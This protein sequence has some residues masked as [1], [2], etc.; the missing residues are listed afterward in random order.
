MTLLFVGVGV[1]VCGHEADF[2]AARKKKEEYARVSGADGSEDGTEGSV[3][4]PRERT[5]ETYGQRRTIGE[6][7][8]TRSARACLVQSCLCRG[9]APG[10]NA[11]SLRRAA[12]T[13]S[14]PR[15]ERGLRRLEQNMHGC[16]AQSPSPPHAGGL[17]TPAGKPGGRP[18]GKRHV[19][20]DHFCV[21]TGRTVLHPPAEAGAGARGDCRSLRPASQDSLTTMRALLIGL[22]RLYQTAVS[23]LLPPNTCRFFP[24]CSEYSCEAIRKH[25]SVRGVWMAV[26]RV[27]RCHPYHP[28]GYDPVP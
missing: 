16:V 20:I 25:G 18:P 8:P 2:S 28:G 26:K 15:S 11:P 14:E 7:V 19:C 13:R 4:P 17:R 24:T 10:G 12:G 9:A 27:A 5:L 23:P 22:I 6:S 21:Q 1:E 3:T